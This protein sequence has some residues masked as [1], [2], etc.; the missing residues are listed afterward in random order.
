MNK[1]DFLNKCK[2]IGVDSIGPLENELDEEG[3]IVILKDHTSVYIIF[4]NEYG[5]SWLE[6]ESNVHYND[7]WKNIKIL[8]PEETKEFY[9]R[10][11]ETLKEKY[12]TPNFEWW[13][14]S[15]AEDKTDKHE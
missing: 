5:D 10:I 2:T 14:S 6:Y 13:L 1:E 12:S 9:K 4:R 8:T 7:R 11:L 3:F 15:Y